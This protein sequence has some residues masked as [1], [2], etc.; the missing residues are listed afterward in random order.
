MAYNVNGTALNRT[1]LIKNQIYSVT[2]VDITNIDAT[3]PPELE[4]NEFDV[5][6]GLIAYYT[7]SPYINAVGKQFMLLKTNAEIDLDLV[8]PSP[9]D[10]W[11]FLGV[12]SDG[13]KWNLSSNLLD[14]RLTGIPLSFMMTNPL[15]S[16]YYSTIIDMNTGKPEYFID[17]V[18]NK[19]IITTGGDAMLSLHLAWMN[20][21][22]QR[23]PQ[24]HIIDVAKLIAVPYYERIIA[25]RSQAQFANTDY[26]IDVGLLQSKLEELKLANAEFLKRIRKWTIVKG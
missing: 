9:D 13:R 24:R 12:T 3:L 22:I 17:E 18:R 23:I 16:S 20:T 15:Q 5:Q 1:N 11:S 19:I 10:C 14:M 26:S 8:K 2:G 7:A 25:L 4:I 21:D 6:S